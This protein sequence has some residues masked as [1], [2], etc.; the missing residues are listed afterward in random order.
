M[1]VNAEEAAKRAK[2]AESLKNETVNTLLNKLQSY[3]IQLQ[4]D[5]VAKT[6]TVDMIEMV[7][8]EIISRTN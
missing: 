8:A 7:K 1:I 6:T 5:V 2:F 3:T 4:G